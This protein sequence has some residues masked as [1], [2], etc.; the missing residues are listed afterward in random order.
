MELNSIMNL[1]NDFDENLDD[2]TNFFGND[3]SLDEL[4]TTTTIKTEEVSTKSEEIVMEKPFIKSELESIPKIEFPL[5]SKQVIIPQSSISCK[6]SHKANL[7]PKRALVILRL[8]KDNINSEYYDDIKITNIISLINTYKKQFDQ[9]IFIKDWFPVDHIIYKNKV[10][11]IC[12]SNTPGA[13]LSNGLQINNNDH[14]LLIN[15][16]NLYT[17]N[18]AFYNA[19]S[20]N[21]V[22]ESNL[23]NILDENRIKQVYLCGITLEQQIY[24]T[25]HDTITFGYECFIVEDLT[26]GKDNKKM[27]KCLTYL[28]K[29]GITIINSSQ[30]KT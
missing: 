9:V 18:S 3:S 8:Q 26:S 21:V 5:I 2:V 10:N 11:K 15:T 25:A 20:N 30:V 4:T 22:K 7:T 14:I 24:F 28:K 19:K 29:L 12:I 1:S 16:L 6:N 13:E 23:K 27:E 17:S